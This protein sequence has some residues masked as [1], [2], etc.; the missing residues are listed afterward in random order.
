MLYR[1]SKLA[2]K[3]QPAR[4]LSKHTQQC[5]LLDIGEEVAVT[6][7]LFF[8]RVADEVVNDALV[9]TLAGQAGDER[10]AENVPA[11]EYPPLGRSQELCKPIRIL[12][13]E[14]DSSKD[15]LAWI[16]DRMTI[17][18]KAQGAFC[19]LPYAVPAASTT[20]SGLTRRGG[21]N[22]RAN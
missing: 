8:G 22:R 13:S 3:R 2:A 14:P 21:G 5:L 16:R 1:K 7:P 19:W 11:L 18:Y 17:H 15:E 4:L 6:A 9:H 12:G 10:V 20:T